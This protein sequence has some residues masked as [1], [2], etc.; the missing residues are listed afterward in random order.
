MENVVEIAESTIHDGEGAKLEVCMMKWKRFSVQ[1]FSLYGVSLFVQNQL[2][3]LRKELDQL[4]DRLAKNDVIEQK[5]QHLLRELVKLDGAADVGCLVQ[6][7]DASIS[8]E[9][10]RAQANAV[11][12][13][14]VPDVCFQA[15]KGVELMRKLSLICA[16]PS[17]LCLHGSA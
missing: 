5:R 6:V 17:C 15:M 9:T 4:R 2:V 13:S 8:D 16:L 7:G 14:R 3:R 12:R 1:I 10:A 11:R